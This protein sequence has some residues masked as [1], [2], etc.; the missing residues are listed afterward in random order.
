M[1]AFFAYLV[2]LAKALPP[3]IM[4]NKP[5]AASCAGDFVEAT[6][7][8]RALSHMCFGLISYPFFA[9][10]CSLLE[11]VMH[12]LMFAPCNENKFLGRSVEVEPESVQLFHRVSSTG[13]DFPSVMT[14]PSLC[15]VG[16]RL[17]VGFNLRDVS[18]AVKFNCF[19]A[20]HW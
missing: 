7:I 9:T 18:V 4:R 3:F 1:Y 15:C 14:A 2:N 12:L 8:P 11:L 17:V 10:R 5:F 16:Y 19:F 6:F 13:Q 20:N